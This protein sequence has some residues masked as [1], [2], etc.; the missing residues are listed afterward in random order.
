MNKKNTNNHT[1][2]THTQASHSSDISSLIDIGKDKGFL[3]Y[4]EINDAFPQDNFS[5]EEM[6]TLLETLGELGIDI[7]DTA[8]KGEPQ[9]PAEA[10]EEAVDVERVEDPVRIYMREM[11]AV[12]LLKRE[13]EIVYAR[14]I[15]ESRAELRRLTL[16][17]PF[18]LREVLRLVDRVKTG[19][20]S[21]RDLIEEAEETIQFDESCS[22]EVL[23]KLEK[24][25]RRKPEGAYK[26]LKDVNLSNSLIRRV[27]KRKVKLEPFI[28][29]HAFDELPELFA[30]ASRKAACWL[31]SA[32]AARQAS[33]VQPAG[34]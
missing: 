17:S 2:N 9:E 4:D 18:A 25:K 5:V 13:E 15:E 21:L 19:R 34:R 26:V 10:K 6:D 29:I 27:V 33:T 32:C 3:T 24:L 11:G 1:N 31:A 20:A 22:D 23:D 8:E 16:S 7:V 14:K 28:E 30:A 12:P